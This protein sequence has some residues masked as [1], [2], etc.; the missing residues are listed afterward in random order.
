MNM[1]PKILIGTPVYQE[2]YYCMDAWIRKIEE[3][4]SESIDIL[5]VDN[6][7]NIAFTEYLKQICRKSKVVHIPPSSNPYESV[8]NSRKVII[9]QLKEGDYSH[10]FS[11]ECDI[12]PEKSVLEELLKSDK[13]VVGV[14]YILCYDIAPETH[15]KCGFIYSCSSLN[16]FLDVGGKK[17]GSFQLTDKDLI[18]APHLMEVYHTGLGCTLLKRELFDKIELHC[19]PENKRFDDSLLFEDLNKAGIK[20]YAKRDLIK[21]VEH[22]PNFKKIVGWVKDD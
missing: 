12:F 5:L 22:Y 6:S 18:N 4:K 8:L 3:F 16:K 7:P 21:L 2:K 19:E 17:T 1:K 14:P 10:W 20:V 9:Q 11:V 13:T 15:L